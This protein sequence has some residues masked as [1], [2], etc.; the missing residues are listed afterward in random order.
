MSTPSCFSLKF[1]PVAERQPCGRSCSHSPDVNEEAKTR[2]LGWHLAAQPGSQSGLVSWFVSFQPVLPLLEIG[3]PTSTTGTAR[4]PG[5]PG[6]LQPGRP[7][8]RPCPRC[9]GQPVSRFTALVPE[10]SQTLLPH[11]APA[12]HFSCPPDF[13]TCHFLCDSR[14]T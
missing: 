13:L 8:H 11:P 10:S 3:A 1:K 9:S 12:L 14:V 4:C 5:T 6:H 2:S 7:R